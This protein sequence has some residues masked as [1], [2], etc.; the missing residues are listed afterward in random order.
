MAFPLPNLSIYMKE[1]EVPVYN[2]S[3]PILT[4]VRGLVRIMNDS[5]LSESSLHTEGFCRK[6]H[7]DKE[8]L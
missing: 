1:L 7:L 3:D 5:D 8:W 2:V 4:T 6:S